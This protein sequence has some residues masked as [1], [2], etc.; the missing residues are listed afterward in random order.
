[1]KGLRGSAPPF[2]PDAPH[3]TRTI[4]RREA[5]RRPYFRSVLGPP[6]VTL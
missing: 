6:S 5:A 2:P 4:W 1:M 3:S